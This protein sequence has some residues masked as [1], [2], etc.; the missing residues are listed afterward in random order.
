MRRWC[1][2]S[3]QVLRHTTAAIR[4]K[5]LSGKNDG[6]KFNIFYRLSSVFFLIMNFFLKSQ[7]KAVETES[8]GGA[9]KLDMRGNWKPGDWE[10]SHGKGLAAERPEVTAEVGTKCRCGCLVNMV[11]QTSR[12]ILAASTQA[13]PG[14]S[15]W[16]IQ[17]DPESVVKLHL[18][19]TKFP[20]P[21]QYLRARNG[22]SLSAELLADIACDKNAPVSGTVVTSESNLL[23]EFFSDETTAAGES[24]IGGFLAHAS[25][26]REFFFWFWNYYF[27]LFWFRNYYYFCLSYNE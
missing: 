24:C 23:L 12:R 27:F 13:C 21:G 10:C 11:N 1:A 22:D 7:G 5:V 19:Q 2:K 18:D 16:L 3:L 6:I 4:S 15:F 14:R 20:C 17:A 8:C 26:F 9:G 25:T